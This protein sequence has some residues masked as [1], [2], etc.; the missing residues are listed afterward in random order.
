MHGATRHDTLLRITHGDD[1]ASIIFP[2]NDAVRGE[3]HPVVR[4]H[5]QGAVQVYHW[6]GKAIA[7]L[8]SGWIPFCRLQVVSYACSINAPLDELRR[9]LIVLGVTRIMRRSEHIKTVRNSPNRSDGDKVKTRR[10]VQ[11]QE[12][13]PAGDIIEHDGDQRGHGK[14]R[15]M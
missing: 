1:A 5:L 12:G 14:F 8:G 3:L 2:P 15:D 6:L 7:A 13:P 4:A 11:Y 9:G 10:V